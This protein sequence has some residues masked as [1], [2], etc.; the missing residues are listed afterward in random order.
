MAP[1]PGSQAVRV[2]EELVAACH[3]ER[4][5]VETGRLD[6]LPDI[7][8]RRGLLLAE[9]DIHLPPGTPVEGRAAELLEQ[10]RMAVRTNL[11]LLSGLRN[12]LARRLAEQET[13]QRAAAGY[14][15]SRGY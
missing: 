14:E 1:L 15:A 2:L 12:E 13:L 3:E 4:Q 5:A 8:T 6:R 11:Q 9:L 7:S 10:A